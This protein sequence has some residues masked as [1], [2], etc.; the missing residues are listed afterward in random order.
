MKLTA[1]QQNVFQQIEEWLKDSDKAANFSAFAGCGKTTVV[2]ALIQKLF[3]ADPDAKITLVAPTHA[4]LLQLSKRISAP[5]ASFKT[6]SQVLNKIPTSDNSKPN[7]EFV[8][9]GRGQLN[10]L[11]IIDESSMLSAS[12]V[13]DLI[14]ICDEDGHILFVGDPAQLP[15]VKQVSGKKLLSEIETQFTLTKIMRAD[16]SIAEQSVLARNNGYFQPSN[17]EDGCV[18]SYENP[19]DLMAA[20]FEKIKTCSPGE[21]VWISRTNAEVNSINFKA[22]KL[23]TGRTEPAAGDSIRLGASSH[24]GKNNTIVQ[25]E[26][27]K[28]STLGFI[29]KIANSESRVEVATP[30]I[31]AE[32][33]WPQIEYLTKQF[34]EN[35]GSPAMAD[36]LEAYRSIVPVSYVYAMTTHKSQGDSIPYVFANLKNIYGSSARYVALSRASK[37]L[38]CT[39]KIEVAKCE[40]SR[41]LHKP[42]GNY[43]EIEFE[44]RY[45]AAAVT[46]AIAAQYPEC[47]PSLSHI[48]CVLNPSHK[49]KSA[50]GWVL[51]E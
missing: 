21:A 2:S 36:E 24:L 47:A 22:H 15:P 48:G 9:L 26:E 10:G 49:S 43:L 25:I 8:K 12:D 30:E 41:W 33:I 14:S 4:A 17:S 1:E 19:E 44:Q 6:V 38:H 42:T 37:E 51:S 32:K 29:V 13:K 3:D 35:N 39:R 23:V 11:A 45:N 27:I 5:G 31:Y 50:K 46:K 7:I 16:N 20:F 28:P 40:G 34:A 18:K